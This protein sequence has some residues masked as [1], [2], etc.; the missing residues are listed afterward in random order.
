MKNLRFEI[1]HRSHLTALFASGQVSSQ[2]LTSYQS[3]Y[4]DRISG[5]TIPALGF[6]VYQ[7]NDAK[8]SV[9]EAFKAGYRYVGLKTVNA[10]APIMAT[11]G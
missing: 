2:A 6:G 4:P 3:E 8:P 1:W 9:L 10:K 7:N 11:C 5:H